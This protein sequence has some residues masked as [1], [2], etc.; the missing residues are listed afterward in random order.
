MVSMT[1]LWSRGIT[2]P[3]Y[4]TR[5]D[6][7]SD[8]DPA[9]RE[10]G[11]HV[12]VGLAAVGQRGSDDPVHLRRARHRPDRPALPYV[13]ELLAELAVEVLVERGPLRGVRLTTTLIEV[14]VDDGVVE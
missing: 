4:E 7:G 14:T 5:V 3:G 8:V 6:L 13:E 1:T 11:G 10:T 2:R 9:H 12:R